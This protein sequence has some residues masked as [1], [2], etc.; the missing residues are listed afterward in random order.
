MAAV[1]CIYCHNKSENTQTGL[2]NS[3]NFNGKIKP[4]I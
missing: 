4:E 1:V 3:C 2:G